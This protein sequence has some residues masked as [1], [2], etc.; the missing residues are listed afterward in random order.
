MEIFNKF[1]LL[2]TLFSVGFIGT[3]HSQVNKVPS[4]IIQAVHEISPDGGTHFGACIIV[5]VDSVNYIITARH[6]LNSILDQKDISFYINRKAKWELL[7][8]KLLLHENSKIDIA[9]IQLE[10]KGVVFHVSNFDIGSKN[11]FA[12][13]ECFFLGY[14]YGKKVEDVSNSFNDGFPVPFIKKGI[15]SAFTFEENGAVAEIFVDATNNSG[16]SGGPVVVRNE[17]GINNKF[18]MRLIG[19]VSGYLS[20]P[21]RVPLKSG[22][23]V[24]VPENSGIMC[25][26][27]INYA[28]DIIK[29]TR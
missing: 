25:S 2:A 17:V 23:V 11:Y 22:E 28:L 13:Q 4:E 7:K 9:V 19:I 20:E 14:P 5:S 6:L 27:P 24:V 18:E 1:G 12:S 8:G 10:Q 26:V 21:R 3:S 15:V 29:R 16:F